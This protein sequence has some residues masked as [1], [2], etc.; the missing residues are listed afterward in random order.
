MYGC[1]VYNDEEI[2][3]QGFMMIV[4]VHSFIQNKLENH[5]HSFEGKGLFNKKTLSFIEN[6]IHMEL[7][8]E[9]DKIVLKRRTEKKEEFCFTFQEKKNTFLL[10][11]G[12]IGNLQIPLYTE[13]LIQ[14]NGKIEIDY[15]LN[16]K[17]K[18]FFKIIYE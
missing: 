13:R 16:E 8:I 15:I 18:F 5:S 10:Y 4:T 9:K 1:N 7:Q 2:E 11:C 6:E 14:E 12:T 17:E 3:G